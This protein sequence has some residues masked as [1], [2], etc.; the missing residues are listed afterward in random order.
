[1]RDPKN[2][3][4]LTDYEAQ[5]LQGIEQYDWAVTKVGTPED[6]EGPRFVY[7][8]GLYYRFRHPEILIYGLPYDSMLQV[9]NDIGSKVRAS[10]VFQVGLSYPDIF[11]GRRC[12]F[13]PVDKIYYRDRLAAANWFYESEKYPTLQ[14]FWPDD[15][16]LFPWDK[17]CNPIVRNAQPQ[18]FRTLAPGRA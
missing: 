17:S 1:M 16:G 15:A 8:T 2:T 18:L 13:Q 4:G 12:Q 11:E 7:T 5:F 6:E 3:Q 10:Y 9:V 14:L